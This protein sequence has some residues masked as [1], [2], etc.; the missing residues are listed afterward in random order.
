MKSLIVPA[1]AANVVLTGDWITGLWILLSKVT[2]T[3]ELRFFAVNDWVVPTPTAVISR[4]SGTGW[5]AFAAVSATLNLFS[6]TFTA[7]T[8]D[9]NLFVTPIPVI[10]V[11]AIPIFIVVPLPIG[12]YV[13]SSP[14]WKKWLSITNWLFTKSIMVSSSESKT[15]WNIGLPSF[16]KLNENLMSLS[17]P[18]Y[19]PSCDFNLE[20]VKVTKPTPPVPVSLRLYWN[21]FVVTAVFAGGVKRSSRSPP[22]ADE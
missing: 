18:V 5:S 6:A 4:V 3:L 17:V 9:G 12:L 8:V 11:A 1:S 7:K 13:I 20:S 21:T 15:L 2:K 16:V 14:V 19:V 10:V 22:D